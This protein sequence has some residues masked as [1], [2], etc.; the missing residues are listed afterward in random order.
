MIA[1]LEAFLFVEIYP[2]YYSVFI[3]SRKQVIYVVVRISQPPLEKVDNFDTVRIFMKEKLCI[4]ISA[5]R[6]YGERR[7]TTAYYAHLAHAFF[8]IVMEDPLC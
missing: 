6:L 3:Y 2:Q 7:L 8:F 5:Q 4:S 1:I